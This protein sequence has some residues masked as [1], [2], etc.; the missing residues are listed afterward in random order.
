MKRYTAKYGFSLTASAG[1][2]FFHYKY[3]IS[4]AIHAGK[5]LLKNAKRHACEENIK[6]MIAGRELPGSTVDFT[7]LRDPGSENPEVYRKKLRKRVAACSQGIEEEQQ[8]I[9]EKQPYLFC[10]PYEV[11][12]FRELLKKIK[13]LKNKGDELS[14]SRLNRLR[15]GVLA[16]RAKAM[17]TTL[18]ARIYPKNNNL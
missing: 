17:Y 6:K 9:E 14:A 13:D 16:G 7:L 2:V 1:I 15:Q 11:S 8:G 18:H 5:E 12:A 4:K 10:R 3:P